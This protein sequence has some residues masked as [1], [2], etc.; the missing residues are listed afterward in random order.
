MWILKENN[1]KATKKATGKEE[2]KKKTKEKKIFLKGHFNC[3]VKTRHG[4]TCIFTLFITGLQFCWT[5]KWFFQGP[6]QILCVTSPH[7]SLSHQSE[8]VGRHL[9]CSA[10]VLMAGE[11][12]A[13]DRFV[14]KPRSGKSLFNL[15]SPKRIILLE[16]GSKRNTWVFAT[17]FHSAESC[18]L[19]SAQAS[20][21]HFVVQL[22]LWG[23][24]LKPSEVLQIHEI[25]LPHFLLFKLLF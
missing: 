24:G 16:T 9:V 2:K 17:H 15:S 4:A 22:D 10:P 8:A 21:W 6:M 1:M 5:N 25:H 18:T 20:F 23:H 7:P 13:R 19:S 14:I 3:A 12:M 11:G